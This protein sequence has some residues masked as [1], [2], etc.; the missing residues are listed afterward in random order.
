[1]NADADIVSL[2]EVTS[3]AW[4]AMEPKLPCPSYRPQPFG[5]EKHLR[6][7]R[8]KTAT[9]RSSTSTYSLAENSPLDNHYLRGIRRNS[10]R[11]VSG[12]TP[13]PRAS[14]AMEAPAAFSRAAFPTCVSV[15]L[16]TLGRVGARHVA[17]DKQTLL[18]DEPRVHLQAFQPRIQ[19]CRP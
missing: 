5:R 7:I 14:E 9:R 3:A 4:S 8:R 16:R 13:R 18:S 11:S 12:S 2:N 15:S 19:K 10:F 1:M 6:L 17:L